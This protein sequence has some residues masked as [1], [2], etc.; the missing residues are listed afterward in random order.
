M[1]IDGHEREDVVTYRKAFVARWAEYE[2][3]MVHFDNEGNEQPITRGFD[4]QQRGRF[5][6]I[7]VTH[8]ESTFFA[9]D[10][11]KNTW[12]PP[13][14]TPTPERKRKG[15]SLMVSDFLTSEWGPLRDDEEYALLCTH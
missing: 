5:R 11:C 12:H 6:L 14:V 7:L 15:E 9:E 3:R 1:Y 4:V 2:K 8:D 13:G 10:R